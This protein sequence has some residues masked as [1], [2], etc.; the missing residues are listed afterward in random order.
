MAIPPRGQ[1]TAAPNRAA[2]AAQGGANANMSLSADG[3]RSIREREGYRSQ[4]YNDT[5]NNC[6]YGVG[7]L[8]HMGPCSVQES[9]AQVI[10]A[11]INN[12]QNTARISYG[13]LSQRLHSLEKQLDALASFV[14]NVPALAPRVLQHVEAGDDAAV[15]KQ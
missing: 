15:T 12:T 1:A 4:Y 9:G 3:R 11:T 6:S 14:F 13:R 2:P 10:D 5:A 8:A 7:Q